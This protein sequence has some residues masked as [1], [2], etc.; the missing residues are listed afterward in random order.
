MRWRREPLR[1]RRGVPAPQPGTAGVL[2][3]A[4]GRRK[5]AAGEVLFRAGEPAYR[6]LRGPERGRGDIDGFDTPPERV[7]GVHGEGRFTGELSLVSGQPGPLGCVCPRG[8]RGDRA[9]PR[10]TEALIATPALGDL[11]LAVPRPPVAADRARLRACGSSARASRRTA[12]VCASSSRATASRTRS[13]TWS[14][15][16]ADQLLRELSIA[17]GRDTP[18]VLAGRSRC[19]TRRN[20]EVADALTSGRRDER[21]RL[22]TV[23]VGAGPAGLAPRSTAPPRA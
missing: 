19:A 3:A 21:D 9:Q 11:L 10:C 12:A 20:D 8:R 1:Q 16:Q 7:L 22:R 6:F 23:V 17:A 18:I 5:M 4:G 2:D 14:D 15:A 13:S